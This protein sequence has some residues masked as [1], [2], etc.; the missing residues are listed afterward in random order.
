MA[1]DSK[2]N[3]AEKSSSGEIKA[4]DG[5]KNTRIMGDKKTTNG[6][7]GSSEA[8]K[9]AKKNRNSMWL[10]A[11]SIGVAVATTSIS[12]VM[13]HNSG[14]IYLDRSRPGFLPDEDEVEEQQGQKQDYKFE[15]SGTLDPEILRIYLQNYQEQ[16]DELDRLEKPF[17]A[18][19]LSDESL[20]IPKE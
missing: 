12:L 2:A 8:E 5:V 11:L 4:A 13:Y 20:G 16:L 3:N 15:A 1:T 10:G 18:T 19:P 6:E 7:K 14:D 17:A 9:G